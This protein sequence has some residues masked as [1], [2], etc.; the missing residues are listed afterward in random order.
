MNQ[1]S[2]SGRNEQGPEQEHPPN[3][4]AIVV[5]FLIMVV[6]IVAWL[7]VIRSEIL[8][9]TS[10]SHPPEVNAEHVLRVVAI[11]RL[12]EG[13][14][15][16]STHTQ[17]NTDQPLDEE[18]PQED[19]T[20]QEL[21][22]NV[23]PAEA[24]EP[25]GGVDIR[26]EDDVRYGI[27]GPTRRRSLLQPAT[28]TEQRPVHEGLQR[29][30]EAAERGAPPMQDRI[31]RANARSVLRHGNPEYIRQAHEGNQR[32]LQILMNEAARDSVAGGQLQNEQDA[33]A[34]VYVFM[35][36]YRNS[37]PDPGILG[38]ALSDVTVGSYNLRQVLQIALPLIAFYAA[39]RLIIN[40]RS[41]CRSK[42]RQNVVSLELLPP[43]VQT[44]QQNP[45]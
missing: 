42:R 30:F 31:F 5:P 41:Y 2:T 29:S 26:Y 33:E 37:L 4:R 24:A 44:T 27:T 3:L 32:A 38:T 9:P 18:S 34:F 8:P 40:L 19:I 45:E 13:W 28:P 23:D 43:S 36:E 7:T 1:Q 17:T 15:E 12:N 35:G 16:S 22:Q 11:A 10:F 20:Q 21:T 14:Q 39:M 6:A 25:I